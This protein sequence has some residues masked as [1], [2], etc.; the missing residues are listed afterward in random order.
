[1]R[2]AR[3]LIASIVAFGIAH[4]GT[5]SAAATDRQT[6]THLITLG[7]RGGPIP[8]KDRAQSSN[9]LVV[10]G[11]PYL[12]DAG[13]GVLRR[14]TQADVN[15]RQIGKVFITH[16]HDDHTAGLGTLMSV[17][18]DFQRHDAI[19]V[20]GPPGTVALV[21]GAIQ[22]FTVNAE[23]RWTEGRRTPLGDVFV[24]HDVAPGLIYRDTN[25]KVTAVENTHF[26]IPAGS[27]YYG[28]YKSYAYR[29]QTP[30]RVIV[31]TGDTGPSDAVTELARDADILVSEIGS[32]E[33]LKQVLIK[34]GA[35]QGMTPEQQTAFVRHLTEEH[36]TPEEVG[37]LAA[38]AN[39]KMV[40]LT[41]PATDDQRP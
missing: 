8:A 25:I 2:I 3:L 12:V 11:T 33:D 28:K 36:L 21:K 13:D 7:T 17:A 26:H 27:P 23:I 30:D 24:G 1:M 5:V 40:V 10:N 4:P 18:W 15:F 9:L 16:G 41:Q 20:Y 32:T 6:G 38:R 39:V 29:F 34:N 35:W 31:F 19:D 37:K 22:Y 14:L